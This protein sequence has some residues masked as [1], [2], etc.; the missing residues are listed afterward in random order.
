METE[1]ASSFVPVVVEQSLLKR[2]FWLRWVL[3]L[4]F[5][6]ILGGIFIYAG[7]LK[8]LDQGAFL[9]DLREFR[10]LPDAALFP[11]AVFLPYLEMIVGGA[12]IIGTPYEG[13][14][15]L[16]GG[17]LVTFGVFLASAAWRG[18]DISCGCFGKHA[19]SSVEMGLLRDG[20]LLLLWTALL[21]LDLRHR[22]R[23]PKASTFR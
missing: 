16:S 18:L 1:S 8:S 13:A 4:L 17:L 10:I 22:G 21:W 2:Q 12:L 3:P 7:F 9:S 6:V 14:L 15:L 20:A 11:T 19:G 23:H 5:R